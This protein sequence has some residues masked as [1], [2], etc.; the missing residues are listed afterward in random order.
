MAGIVADNAIGWAQF[1]LLG[2]WRNTLVTCG[3]YA[4]IAGAVV[5]ALVKGVR[6]SSAAEVL[7]YFV[8]LFLGVQVLVLL[9]YGTTRAGQ[10][11]RADVTGKLLESHR[12]MPT[13]PTG[14][15]IGYLFGS[16]AQAIGVFAVNFV[17]GAVC[18]VGAGYRLKSWVL[19]NGVLLLFAL[20]IWTITIFFSFRSGLATL[21][22]VMLLAMPVM[23]QGV[24]LAVVPGAGVLCS[25]MIGRT[26]FDQRI[27]V[28]LDSEY[29]AAAMGQVVIGALY[30]TAAAR[31]YRRDDAIG[32]DTWLGL[33]LLAVWTILSVFGF[34][35]LTVASWRLRGIVGSSVLPAFV[36]SA[37][38]VMLLSILP[39]SGAVRA[40]ELGH[41]GRRW[42]PAPLL[43]SLLTAL[44]ACGVIFSW[45]VRLWPPF[46]VVPPL[47]VWR[48]AAVI[49]VF[50]VGVRYVLGIAHRLGLG[51]RMVMILWLAVTWGVPIMAEMIRSSI[52]DDIHDRIS[53]IAMCSPPS[54][55]L[56][57]WSR[58]PLIHTEQFGGL[59][60]QC[61]VAALAALIFHLL[62]P[63]SNK[64]AP[65]AV[66]GASP[67]TG[68][69]L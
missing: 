38:S 40:S 51:P 62:R 30:I 14:A 15:V 2:G 31:R 58:D 48:T 63:R 29:I 55:L 24:Q 18:A 60:V 64:A 1:R 5:L 17:F 45:E 12:L 46:R 26:I 54:E 49:A 9:L 16:T 57:L 42:Q 59:A 47:V 65:T 43:A 66:A 7:S 13:P 10:S 23:S 56:Q 19:A 36:G 61:A 20:F 50:V 25:P 68:I 52:A 22:A 41:A 8:P 6:S 28:S 11:V 37:C 33:A 4:F 67:S 69:R 3:T 53:Q 35:Q 34:R 32:F 44:V 39:V 21:G 27:G